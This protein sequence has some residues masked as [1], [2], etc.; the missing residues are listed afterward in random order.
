MGHRID[1][2]PVITTPSDSDKIVVEHDNL[3]SQITLARLIAAERNRLNQLESALQS[4]GGGALWYSFSTDSTITSQ[5]EA[6]PVGTYMGKIS[7]YGRQEA[8][9]VPN[10]DSYYVYSQKWT[11]NNIYIR[12]T[13]S[14]QTGG[15]YYKIKNSSGWASDWTKEPTR[16][17][18]TSLNNSLTNGKLHNAD[19]YFPNISVGS[20]LYVDLG[21]IES[22]FGIPAGSYIVSPFIRGWSGNPGALS[23]A[24]SSNGKNLYLMCSATGTISSVTVRVWYCATN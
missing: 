18:I 4:I 3:T 8:T 1:E 21:D 23:L 12:L 17:E 11:D 15:C 5:L 9:G 16:T 10:N 2:L 19:H 6:L 7:S 24:I 22:V 14:T 20:S 13:S